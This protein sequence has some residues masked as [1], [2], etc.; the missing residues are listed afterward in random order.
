SR[1]YSAAIAA[2]CWTLLASHSTA[3]GAPRRRARSRSR[4]R[5]PSIFPSAPEESREPAAASATPALAHDLQ[6][7]QTLADAVE[8]DRDVLAGGV[9]AGGDGCSA[10]VGLIGARGLAGGQL[11]AAD[12]AV[13]AHRAV[14]VAL[15]VDGVLEVVDLAQLLGGDLLSEGDPG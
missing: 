5:K 15:L 3:S 8:A 13:V 6:G 4:S 2:T 7:E 14:A 11:D 1:A 10:D 12:G 9:R